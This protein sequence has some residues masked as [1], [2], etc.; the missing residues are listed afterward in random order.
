MRREFV[1]RGR[2][3]SA[4]I[5]VVGHGES[6]HDCTQVHIPSSIGTIRCLSDSYDGIRNNTMSKEVD[7][8]GIEA[9]AGRF[10]FDAQEG[11]IVFSE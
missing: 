5:R 6:T 2:D 1:W 10:G 4:K 8:E 9:F 7:W 3:N 11:P